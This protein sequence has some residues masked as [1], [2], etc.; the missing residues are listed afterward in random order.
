MQRVSR[1]TDRHCLPSAA[2]SSRAFSR[3]AAFCVT[4]PVFTV[5]EHVLP[6]LLRALSVCLLSL[7]H[8]QGFGAYSAIPVPLP[9]ADRHALLLPSAAV[10]PEQRA[11]RG[12]G[13]V[14][15]RVGGA[16]RLPRQLRPRP[17]APGAGA[18]DAHG[19][20]RRWLPADGVGAALPHTVARHGEGVVGKDNSCCRA[21]NAC[22]WTWRFTPDLQLVLGAKCWYLKPRKQTL[23]DIPWVLT[24]HCRCTG[25]RNAAAAGGHRGG[26]CGTGG[27][28]AAAAVV[29]RGPAA[30]VHGSAHDPGPP[31]RRSAHEHQTRPLPRHHRWAASCG[32]QACRCAPAHMR[33]DACGG[34]ARATFSARAALQIKG[35]TASKGCAL[36]SQRMRLVSSCFVRLAAGASGWAATELRVIAPQFVPV[37]Q[38]VLLTLKTLD[39]HNASQ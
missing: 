3:C 28:A 2:K 38:L 35:S 26:G 15:G 9:H 36:T 8:P 18:R 7:N 31:A 4:P 34:D 27:S 37:S 13:A 17:P 10:R 1:R 21:H 22:V 20:G 29:R 12:G 23:F 14:A 39:E 5:F 19:C 6:V 25:V 32:R 16:G 11:A 30:A 33:L 24:P